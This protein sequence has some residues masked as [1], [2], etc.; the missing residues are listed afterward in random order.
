MGVPPLSFDSLKITVA[1][2]VSICI[3][4]DARLSKW[5]M[6]KKHFS[7]EI[8]SFKGPYGINRRLVKDTTLFHFSST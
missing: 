6:E 3:S 8:I 1:L 4:F 7:L 5:V 2:N